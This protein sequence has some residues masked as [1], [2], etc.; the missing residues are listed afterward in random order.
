MKREQAKQLA[1]AVLFV[2]VA[3]LLLANIVRFVAARFG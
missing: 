2:L 3:A 1:Y